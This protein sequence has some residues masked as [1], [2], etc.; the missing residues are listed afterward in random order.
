M[1]ENFVQYFLDE[2]RVLVII[3]NWCNIARCIKKIPLKLKK[4]YIKQ[5]N[6]LNDTITSNYYF[7]IFCSKPMQSTKS[8]TIMIMFLTNFKLVMKYACTC[9]ES[10]SYVDLEISYHF[11]NDLAPSPGKKHWTK[12]STIPQLTPYI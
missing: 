8:D 6:V 2:P 3:Q 4:R 12:F 11:D 7:M 10:D 1:V 5:N 9:G